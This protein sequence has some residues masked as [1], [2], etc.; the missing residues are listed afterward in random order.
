MK[1]HLEQKSFP[2]DSEC[3]KTHYEN[4]LYKIIHTSVIKKVTCDSCKKTKRFKKLKK[5]YTR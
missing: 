2:W 1:I 5:Q 4:E 3:G